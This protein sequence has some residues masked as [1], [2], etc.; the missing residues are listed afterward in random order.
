MQI[1]PVDEDIAEAL[2][3][4]EGIGELVQ[5]VQPGEAAEDAGLQAGD[6]V[7]AVN[8]KDVTPDNTLSRIVAN[9][10]PGTTV[11]LTYIR[12][13]ERN[14]VNLVVGADPATKS[15]CSR[16]CSRTM[17][18]IRL[19]PT[20]PE[21]GSGLMEELLG[22]Q[23]VEITPQIARQLGQSAD[24]TGLAILGRCADIGRSASRSCPR[25]DDPVR[26]WPCRSATWTSWKPC[27]G[28]CRRMAAKPCCCGSARA[29]A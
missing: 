29:R 6:V 13:G 12:N 3:I 24:T 10:A 28:R 16:T 23:A 2:G 9:I 25:G 19:R 15:C 8:G 11:P 27:C 18:R 17:T 4:D 22:I 26:Q 1:Q 7:V 14:R 5:G 20:V 21:K